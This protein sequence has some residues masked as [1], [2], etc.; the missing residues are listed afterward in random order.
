MFIKILISLYLSSILFY[1]LSYIILSVKTHKYLMSIGYVKSSDT[2]TNIVSLL[3]AT[4]ITFV[5][6]IIPIINIIIG[7]DFIT[8][9]V[10]L[11]E[12]A[13]IKVEYGLYDKKSS[14]QISFFVV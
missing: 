1:F 4:I 7:H 2:K 9:D 14:W 6:S 10:L 11:Y 8:S 3:R 13:I 5:I 12:N